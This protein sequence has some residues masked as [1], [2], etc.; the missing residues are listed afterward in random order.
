MRVRL[1]GDVHGLISR[2]ARLIEDVPYSIQLGDMGFRESYRQLGEC[3]VDPTRHRFVPGNH[4]EYPCLPVHALGDYG[5]AALA[6]FRFFYVRGALS[7]DRRWR[8]EGMTWWPQEELTAEQGS[9]VVSAYRRA[10]PDIVLSH[11]CPTSVVSL[12]L[13]NPMKVD[14]SRTGDMLQSLLDEHA[15]SLW[16]FAHHHRTHRCEVAGTQ[17]ICLGELRCLDYDTETEQVELQSGRDLLGGRL[18]YW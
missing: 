9:E 11:D 8:T 16:V 14:P 4:D 1:I 12:F 15:P 10:R 18:P 2:Y 6:G 3:G 7:V 13:T 5:A 17:F